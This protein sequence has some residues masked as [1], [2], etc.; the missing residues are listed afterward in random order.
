MTKTT[1]TREQHKALIDAVNLICEY[2]DK[3]LP[4]GFEIHLVMA[5]GE[6]CMELIYPEWD[7]VEDEGAEPGRSHLVD[8]CELAHDELNSLIEGGIEEV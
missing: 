6:A 8:L 7:E 3:H 1:V 5:H 2:S 4:D